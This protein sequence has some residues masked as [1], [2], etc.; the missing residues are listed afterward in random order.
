MVFVKD[1]LQLMVNLVVNN[2]VNSSKSMYR[3]V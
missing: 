2:L 1:I 3:C